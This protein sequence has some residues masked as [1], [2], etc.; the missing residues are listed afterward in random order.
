MLKAHG[1]SLG[2]TD[3]EIVCGL[4]S[5]SSCHCL[6]NSV[7]HFPHPLTRVGGIP[8][9]VYRN[10]QVTVNALHKLQ[11]LLLCS[12]VLSSTKI[13]SSLSNIFHH[14]PLSHQN[15]VLPDIF[16]CNI[17]SSLLRGLLLGNTKRWPGAVP[18]G[19]VLFCTC[20]QV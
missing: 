7:R 9:P 8:D 19:P 18:E 3:R 15:K 5:S 16:R 4:F 2:F 20:L 13:I 10:D 6:F 12:H 1:E 17:F 14:L 11:S